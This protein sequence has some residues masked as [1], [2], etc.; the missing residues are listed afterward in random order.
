[1]AHV[2]VARDG[3]ELGTL[4]PRMNHYERQREPIGTPAVRSS[5]RED[6][7]LSVMNID[8]DRGHARPARARQPDGRLDLDRHRASWRWAAWWRSCRSRP[9]RRAA[10]APSR[11]PRPDVALSHAAAAPGWPR[12]VNRSVL[13]A[14]LAL[15]LPLVAILVANLGRDPHAIGSPLVGRAG[16]RL[17][18]CTPV[19][20]GAPVTLA[21]LRGQPVVLNFWATWCVPCFEEHA[22]LTARR[23]AA[24]GPTSTSSASSTR[25]ARRASRP[26]SRERGGGYPSL[27][28]PDSKTAIAYG[29]FGVPETFFID[30]DGRIAAKYVGPLD[31]R[32]SGLRA[33]RKARR[34]RREAR[35]RCSLR[36]RSPPVARALARAQEAAG[37]RDP[38]AIVGRAAR[39]GPRRAKRSPRRPRDVAALLRCPVCQGLS[40]ADSPATMAQNM[41][42]QVRELL[43]AGYD[44]RRRCSRT[45]S[46]RTAS[47]CASSRRCAA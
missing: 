7:Y 14:G 21:A 12:P 38:R 42:A 15:A 20:G 3:H 33:W 16:A 34:A 9:G 6:L 24:S 2:A 18:R 27:V 23:R 13:V 4:S 46:T 41:K 19:D 28:D 22:V 17:S 31:A 26:S 47:S 25:T 39:S 35:A 30:A 37:A 1:M 5:L 40:V 11:W 45:S 32:R 43:A 10:A 29:V 36:S 8:A 44:Q